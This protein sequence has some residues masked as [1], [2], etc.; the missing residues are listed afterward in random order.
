MSITS[1]KCNIVFWL[2]FTVVCWGCLQQRNLCMNLCL[3]RMALKWHPQCLKEGS[4]NGCWMLAPKLNNE[5]TGE[6]PISLY[7][8]KVH[9][10][11]YFD[12]QVCQLSTLST[13]QCHLTHLSS[14]QAPTCWPNVDFVAPVTD[15]HVFWNLWKRKQLLFDSVGMTT[16]LY[17]SYTCLCNLMSHH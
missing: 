15:R 16:K 10:N 14:I 17:R 1:S 8:Y 5:V 3:W 2:C 12:W 4:S 13:G 6:T 9:Q 7:K 11:Q